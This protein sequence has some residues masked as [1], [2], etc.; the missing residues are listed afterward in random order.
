MHLLCELYELYKLYKLAL[1]ALLA[2]LYNWV[3]YLLRA[4]END[5][6]Y[7]HFTHLLK[8]KTYDT[9]R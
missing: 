5:G 9:I 2:K 7:P 3:Q 6:C 8:D 1:S 4:L